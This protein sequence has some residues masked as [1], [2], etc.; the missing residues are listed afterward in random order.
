MK[1]V[2]IAKVDSSSL[3]IISSIEKILRSA[4]NNCKEAQKLMGKV[5]ANSGML[6]GEHEVDEAL[7]AL[8]RAHKKCASASEE[9]KRLNS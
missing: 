4:E 2:L 3:S 9:L 7:N 1:R 6:C 8:S 5:F